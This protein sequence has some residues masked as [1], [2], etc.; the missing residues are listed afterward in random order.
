MI[1]IFWG[2]LLTQSF[3]LSVFL[4]AFTAQGWLYIISIIDVSYI[5]LLSFR[6]M[7]SDDD[8]ED[9]VNKPIIYIMMGYNGFI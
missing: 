1:F 6:I 2:T 5:F 8:D 9:D 3:Y 4:F 7:E